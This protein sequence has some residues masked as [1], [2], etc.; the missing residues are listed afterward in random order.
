MEELVVTGFGITIA[1]CSLLVAG[2]SFGLAALDRDPPKA[3]LI[4]LIAVEVLLAAQ[5][6]L[7]IAALI[8]GGRPDSLATYLSYLVGCLFVLPVGTVWALA[9]RSR[10]STVVL[11]VT[12]LAIPVMVLR[13]S[14]VWHG[15]S[16]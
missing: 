16:A 4:G 15:A 12:C 7:G 1:V 6:V 5:L 14:E 10:S 2:W 3:L 8:G 13:L 9:E 11:G